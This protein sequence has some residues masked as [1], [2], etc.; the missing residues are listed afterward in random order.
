MMGASGRPGVVCLQRCHCGM[1]VPNPV[2]QKHAAGHATGEDGEAQGYVGQ[3]VWY[4]PAGRVQWHEAEPIWKGE[5]RG[6]QGRFRYVVMPKRRG[7]PDRERWEYLSKDGDGWQGLDCPPS[8]AS[9]EQIGKLYAGHDPDS[10][11][12]FVEA[13]EQWNAGG[14]RA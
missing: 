8:A 12:R 2:W 4:D 7:E 11:R 6:V 5:I 13:V 10:R 3:G 1:Y 9:A 14:R